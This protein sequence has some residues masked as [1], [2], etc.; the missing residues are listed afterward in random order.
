MLAKKKRLPKEEKERT[1][2]GFSLFS[3]LQTLVLLV[4][5]T[6]YQLECINAG[7]LRLRIVEPNQK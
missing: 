4:C 2:C 1:V 5:I 7:F 6:S 3:V